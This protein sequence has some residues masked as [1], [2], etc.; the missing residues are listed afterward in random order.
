MLY[1]N[2][3]L[4]ANILGVKQYLKTS[5]SVT[6]AFLTVELTD[7]IIDLRHAVGV[8]ESAFISVKVLKKSVFILYKSKGA[9]LF[10]VI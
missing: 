10:F 6:F 9:Y 8:T 3:L 7:L 5:S 2:N 1:A 4:A